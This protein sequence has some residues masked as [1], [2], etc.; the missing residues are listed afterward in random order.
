MISEVYNED[1]FKT[2]KRIKDKSVNLIVCDSPYFK[3]CG[4]FDWT[5]K[6]MQEWIDWHILLRDEFE[7]IMADNGSLFVFGD[8]KNIAY[9]Q[10]EFDRKFNLLNSLVY[11]K[12]NAQT[13]KG[14]DGFHCFAPVTE[15]ILFYDKGENKTGLEMIKN[16]IETPFAKIMKDEM[17]K[18]NITQ[19]QISI[20]E[21]SKNG[22][23]TG[24]VCNK[25]SSQELPT[26]EQWSKICNLFKIENY[27]EDLRKEY[28]DLRKEYEDLRRPFNNDFR[29][30][31]V[32]DAK[33]KS[34]FHP[35]TKDM[36]VIE[37]LILTTTKENDL[38]FSPFLGSGTDRIACHNTKRNLISCEIDKDYF[39]KANDRYETHIK[40]LTLF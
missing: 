30:T 23:P 38:V 17:L 35:T 29:L 33:V 39:D 24:W 36:A 19:K 14:L 5:F 2:M 37:K 7:R 34:S 12:V 28:E 6:T 18:Q 1:V 27:F 31:D 3:I 20:L 21:L 32:I 15:R 40:Q 4:G 22:K 11:K 26:K 13:V 8:E 9:L 25:L 16:L 10:V